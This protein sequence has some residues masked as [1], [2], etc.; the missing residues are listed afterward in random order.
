MAAATKR[1]Q[2]F[3]GDETHRLP[4]GMIEPYRI[5]FEFLKLGF[6]DP[7]LKVDR[8]LYADW[9]DVGNEEFRAWWET[10]WRDLFGVPLDVLV[11]ELPQAHDHVAVGRT[12]ISIQPS[13]P[14][15]QTLKEIKA[16]MKARGARAS[17][18]D[19][20]KNRGARF[21]LSSGAEVKRKNMQQALKVYELALSL[22]DNKR[23]E[24]AQKYL[25]WANDWNE[26]IRERGWK[27]EPILVPPYLDTFLRQQR[28]ET[29]LEGT[30][31]G[32]NSADSNRKKVKRL[33]D[34]A[35]TIAGNVARGEFPGRY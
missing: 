15:E 16:I 11:I 3:A 12:L 2:K 21:S 4:A 14:I 35:R 32:G 26:K 10:H 23:I 25:D 24:I 9:G 22:G 13:A 19:T 17:R 7:K 29:V 27:R 6:R 34:R 1:R 28:G 5:W 18:K 20:K 31:E 33:I 8:K 30:A